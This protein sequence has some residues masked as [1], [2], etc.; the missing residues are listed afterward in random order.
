MIIGNSI[1]NDHIDLNI[2]GPI[3]TFS[4]VYIL[5]V[6]HIQPPLLCSL[7]LSYSDPFLHPN[8]PPS[9]LTS[10]LVSDKLCLFFKGKSHYES[11][12]GAEFTV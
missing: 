7:G 10:F 8:D 12:A 11:R 5:Y 6:D 3:V 4:Y 9:T 2:F 1:Y